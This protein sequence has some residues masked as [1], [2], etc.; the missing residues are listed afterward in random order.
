MDAIGHRLSGH[1]ESRPGSFD[2]VSVSLAAGG[3][4]I[5]VVMGGTRRH[6][7]VKATLVLHY[8]VRASNVDAFKSALEAMPAEHE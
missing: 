4:R 7:L 8:T 6:R 1:E 5:A 3:F 2:D